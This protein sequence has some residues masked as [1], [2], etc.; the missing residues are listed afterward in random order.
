MQRFIKFTQFHQVHTVLKDLRSLVRFRRRF[1]NLY[2][3]LRSIHKDLRSFASG[4][5]LSMDFQK[6]TTL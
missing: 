2:R 4:V 1:I 5:S 3:K 6:C